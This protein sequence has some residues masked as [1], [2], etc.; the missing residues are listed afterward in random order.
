LLLARL[1]ANEFVPRT[2]T[3]LEQASDPTQRFHYLFVLRNP[4]VGWTPELREVYFA[5]LA[6]MGEFVGGEGMPTF[7]RLIE[8]EA[9]EAVPAEERG[10]YSKMLLGDLLGPSWADSAETNRPLVQKWTVEELADSLQDVNSSRDVERGQRIFAA[11]RCIACHRAGGPGGVSG[12]DLTSAARRFAPRDLLTSILEPS[13]VVAENYRNDAF[14]LH[15][16]RVIVG[17]V[18]P[19]DYR[20]PGLRVIPDLLAPE[21]IVTFSKSEIES[22]RPSPTSPMPSGLLDTFTREEILDLLAFLASLEV[23]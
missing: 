14:T 10:R 12:P 4:K 2:V 15:D 8:N 21:K 22:Q 5:H 9:L 11:A 20:S 1:G 3:L 6:R 18:V 17:R 23:R 19:G 16:G 13:R 7:R